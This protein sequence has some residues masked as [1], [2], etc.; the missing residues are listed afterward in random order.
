MED[1]TISAEDRLK[2]IREELHQRWVHLQIVG[3]ALT[4]EE[5]VE[6]AALNRAVEHIDQAI[7]ALEQKTLDTEVDVP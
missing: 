3:R 1:R 6:A 7:Q 5:Q 2:A 4:P